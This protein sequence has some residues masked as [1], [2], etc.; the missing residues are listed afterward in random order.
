MISLYQ[1]ALAHAILGINYTPKAIIVLSFA[2]YNYSHM[3]AI[4]PQIALPC[5]LLYT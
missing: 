5:V 4:A 1:H 3:S 2:S